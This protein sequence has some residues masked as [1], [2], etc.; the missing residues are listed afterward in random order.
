MRGSIVLYLLPGSGGGRKYCLFCLDFHQNGCYW[1]HFII[2]NLSEN[3]RIAKFKMTEDLA[4]ISFDFP[5]LRM[6]L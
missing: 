3:Q 6:S 4:T 1:A 5:L 2:K